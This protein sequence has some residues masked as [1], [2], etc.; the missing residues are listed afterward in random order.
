METTQRNL[1]NMESKLVDVIDEV[2]EISRY[3]IYS[4]EFRDFMIHPAITSSDYN[5]LNRIRSNLS[6]FFVF[7]QSEK[8]YFHSVQ[9]EG[10]NGQV[11]SVGEIVDAAESTWEANAAELK[12]NILW[13]EPYQLYNIRK[14]QDETVIT[15]YRMINHLYHI[16]EPI[17]LVKFRL[18][19][20]A[21]FRH[22]S[23]GF[24]NEQHEAFLFMINQR[25]SLALPIV[26][27]LNIKS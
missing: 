9:I 15:L 19:Q 25:M 4:N 26:N 12:G 1:N 2:E 17:G 8:D 27:H 7:H 21:L 14:N 22:V 10:Q 3:I 6:G 23:T 20:E 11:L 24:V 13:S 18:D 5:V 16:K